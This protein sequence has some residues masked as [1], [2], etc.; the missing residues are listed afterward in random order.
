MLEPN[1]VLF[2]LTLWAPEGG[3]SKIILFAKQSKK[4]TS[5]SNKTWSSSSSN[6][7]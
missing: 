6:T 5:Q 2:V 7:A 3:V 1:E 4:E